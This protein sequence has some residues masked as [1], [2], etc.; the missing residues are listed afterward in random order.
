LNITASSRPL[1]AKSSIFFKRISSLFYFQSLEIFVNMWKTIFEKIFNFQFLIFNKFSFIQ[2]S[3]IR[4]SPI[5]KKS[6]EIHDK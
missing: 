6:F 4:K 2:F 5:I 1:P 3:N